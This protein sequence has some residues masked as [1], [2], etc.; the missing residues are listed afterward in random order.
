MEQDSRTTRVAM[1]TIFMGLVFVLAALLFVMI[2][3][4]YGPTTGPGGFPPR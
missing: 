1:V 4:G 2:V 3:Y